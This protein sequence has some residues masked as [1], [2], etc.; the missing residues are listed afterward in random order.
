MTRARATAVLGGLTMVGM[1]MLS[2]LAGARAEQSY[3]YQLKGAMGRACLQYAT[4]SIE[5]EKQDI[6]RAACSFASAALQKLL[7]GDG[8]AEVLAA[9]VASFGEEAPGVSALS[10]CD[11]CI[12]GISD[13]EAYLATNGTAANIQDALALSCLKQFTKKA[14]INKC[15]QNVAAVS[16]PRLIDFAL[17]N[18]PPTAACTQ[19][20]LCPQ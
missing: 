11:E 2:S 4:Q 1:L 9:L 7:P 15:L 12:E 5:E 18:L 8:D 13:L 16:V 14:Q 10:S 19:L 17:A 3:F 20:Q 6:F